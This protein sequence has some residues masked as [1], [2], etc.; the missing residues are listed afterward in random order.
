MGIELE[1]TELLFIQLIG[2]S[3][4]S[5]FEG[6]TPPLKK[7]MKWLILDAIC[8]GFY[9]AFHHWALALPIVLLIPGMIIHF[10]WCKKNGIH[11]VKATPRKKY[12]ELRG[13]KWLE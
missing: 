10:R 4:F 3:F 1:L 7:I 2:N 9:F 13:W 12:Y 6:E 5:G 11:P 8:I